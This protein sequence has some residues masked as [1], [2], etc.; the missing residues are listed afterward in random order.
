MATALQV[1]CRALRVIGALDGEV[2]DHAA[3]H[4]FAELNATLAGWGMPPATA[5]ADELACDSGDLPAITLTLAE[6]IAPRYGREL[7]ATS[8]AALAEAMQRFRLRYP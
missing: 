4:G 8:Q 7:P 5:Y 1:I 3:D 2:S 6:R